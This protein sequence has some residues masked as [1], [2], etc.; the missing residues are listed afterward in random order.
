MILAVSGAALPAAPVFAI[1]TAGGTLAVV[2]ATADEK[3]VY[4]IAADSVKAL[5][6]A[7]GTVPL[8]ISHPVL[9]FSDVV[10]GM[11][12]DI[13]A[14][15]GAFPAGTTVTVKTVSSTEVMDAVEAAVAESVV[16]NDE[17]VVEAKVV[18]VRA[19]DITFIYNGEEI[20]PLLPISVVLCPVETETKA[21]TAPLDLA[22]VHIDEDG[23]GSAV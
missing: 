18:E 20:Q 17:S 6:W 15:A 7:D 5:V 1:L 19:L 11:Q 21:E 22:V 8:A 2:Q 3:G 13:D 4:A 16:E 23:N 14:P 10:D 9:S 12:V